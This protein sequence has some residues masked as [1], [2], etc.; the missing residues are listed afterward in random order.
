M[1]KEYLSPQVEI[2]RLASPIS[3]LETFSG[4]GEIE[5]FDDG[6]EWDPNGDG[7]WFD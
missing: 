5:E 7:D 3:L 6:G 2:L 1:K 4:K